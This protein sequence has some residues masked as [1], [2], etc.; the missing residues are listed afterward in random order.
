MATSRRL[1]SSS[2]SRSSPYCAPLQQRRLVPHGMSAPLDTAVPAPNDDAYPLPASLLGLN[3]KFN[4]TPQLLKAS[5]WQRPIWASASL[6]LTNHAFVF[7]KSSYLIVPYAM[8]EHIVS[9]DVRA[10]FSW[11]N[12]R[13]CPFRYF[14]GAAVAL[15]QLHHHASAPC[16]CGRAW[17]E[18]TREQGARLGAVPDVWR[19]A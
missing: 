2:P 10:D 3:S 11:S 1:L 5:D 16:A 12:E 13:C 4:G 15:C 7:A 6:G 18:S 8:E 17:I 9:F 14:K 19:P